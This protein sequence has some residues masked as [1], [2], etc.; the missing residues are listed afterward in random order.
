MAGDE[1][2]KQGAN[3]TYHALTTGDYMTNNK[4]PLRKIMEWLSQFSEDATV[5]LTE[6]H[7]TV[8]IPKEK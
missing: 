1:S 3:N 2:I 5:K 8:I 4:L 6:G 7:I